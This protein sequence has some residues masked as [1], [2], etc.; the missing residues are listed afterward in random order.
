VIRRAYGLAAAA[1]LRHA[2]VDL[3]TFGTPMEF[4][5]DSFGPVMRFVAGTAYAARAL[6]CRVLGQGPA[7]FSFSW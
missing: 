6:T 4:A 3:R 1:H 5:E 2:N 7:P